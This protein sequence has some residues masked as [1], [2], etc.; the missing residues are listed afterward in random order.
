MEP[1][2]TGV[3][4]PQKPPVSGTAPAIDK[5]TNISESLECYT[6][7]YN[8]SLAGKNRTM[9]PLLFKD[10]FQQI[11]LTAAPASQAT[12]SLQYVFP[13]DDNNNPQ[14][15]LEPLEASQ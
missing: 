1:F 13:Y 14:T 5:L 6:I 11:L 9:A 3:T 12:Q 2:E 10:K 7:F 4:V 15:L 8:P